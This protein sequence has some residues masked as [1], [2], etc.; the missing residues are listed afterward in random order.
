MSKYNT[1]A[2]VNELR[3]R[4]GMEREALLRLSKID[5]SSLRRI[6]NEQQHPSQN[7]LKKFVEAVDLPTDGFTNSILDELPMEVI[8]LCDKLKQFLD[9]DDI[10]SAE[11]IMNR[12]DEQKTFEN[13]VLK[14]FKLCCKAWLW[15]LQE[16]PVDD[17]LQLVKEGMLITFPNFKNADIATAIFILEEPELLHIKARLLAKSGF[18]D[19]SIFILENL[20]ANFRKIPSAD[21]EKEHQYT[22]LLLTLS[23][24]LIIKGN[25]SK[26]LELCEIGAEYSATHKRGYYNPDFEFNK[27]I[28]LFGLGQKNNCKKHLKHAYFGFVLLGKSKDAENLLTRAKNEFD[29]QFSTYNVDE[30]KITDQY[31]VPFN[32][33]AAVECYSLGTM[34]RTLRERVNLTQD[35]LSC[36]ICSKTTLF[37]I[38]NDEMTDS[39]FTVEAI[40]QRLGRDIRLYKNFFL[41]KNDFIVVQI[42]DRISKSITERQYSEATKLLDLLESSKKIAKCNILQQFIKMSRAIVYKNEHT[43]SQEEYLNMLISALHITCPQFNERE[44]EKYVLTD[45]EIVLINIYASYIGDTG[46]L[47]REAEILTQLRKN[48]NTKYVDDFEKARMYPIILFNLSSSLGR[49]ERYNE[50]IEIAVEG[51]TFERNHGRLIDLPGFIFNMGYNL[52]LHDKKTESI[53]YLALAYYG[54][55][56]FA[57]FGE[58]NCLPIIY[59]TAKTYTNITFD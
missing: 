33:G 52:I 39:F 4:I 59:E 48:L 14:Q 11:L 57:K 3:K 23:N 56:L 55:S 20:I 31:R 17:I 24:Y 16:K 38:E 12:I 1:S 50:A 53:P 13:D 35:Q 15:E 37:R 32:R 27:A 26:V 18:L 45:N 51:E 6:E 25:Y 47:Q 36:G 28:A 44:I 10:I 30:L 5:E 54:S 9:M 21:K 42:R 19:D 49:A 46:D 41:S 43:A 7:T 22:A 2:L 29:I 40:M 8:L 34:I 58:D